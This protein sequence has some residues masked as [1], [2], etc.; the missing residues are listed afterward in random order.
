M[1]F[2]CAFVFAKLRPR[3]YGKTKVDCST[4]HG[5]N[6]ILQIQ[7]EG[8]VVLV[9][10]FCPADQDMAEV[11]K[12]SPVSSFVCVADR[13][14]GNFAPESDMIKLG[15]HSMET[16]FEVTEYNVPRELDTEFKN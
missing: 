16:S 11:S 7:F 3:K 1:K 8:F 6:G 13:A 10:H 15:L 4:V 12:N 9:Q 2:D 5:I 14:E